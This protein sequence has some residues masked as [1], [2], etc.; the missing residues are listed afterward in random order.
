MYQP[1][2]SATNQLLGAAT[3]LGGAY[4]MGGRKEGGMVSSYADGGMADSYPAGL[5]DLAIYNMG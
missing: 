4:L 2:P 1:G 3:S 5:A